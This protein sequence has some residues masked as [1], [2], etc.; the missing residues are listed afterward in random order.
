MYLITGNNVLKLTDISHAVQTLYVA[1]M[2][3]AAD[4]AGLKYWVDNISKGISSLDDTRAAFI[5]QIEYT[6]IYGQ[7]STTALVTKLYQ[8]LFERDPEKNGLDYWVGELNKQ[9]P[10]T[11]DNLVATLVE[12]AEEGAADDAQVLTNKVAVADNFTEQSAGKKVDDNFNAFAK[13][14]VEEV[15]LLASSVSAGNSRVIETVTTLEDKFL[16]AL[17]YERHTEGTYSAQ[18]LLLDVGPKN[19]NANAINLTAPAEITTNSSGQGLTVTL[20]QGE[21]KAGLQFYTIFA[22]QQEVWSSYGINFSSDFDFTN[23]TKLPGLAGNAPDGSNAS[24]NR[25]L[26]ENGGFSFRFMV[27][28]DGEIELYSYLPGKAEGPGLKEGLIIDGA[29]LF[30]ERETD[31]TISQHLTMNTQGQ[32]NGELEVFIN[33]QLALK[34]TDLMLS[35]DGSHGANR[36]YNDIWNGGNSDNFAA[37]NDSSVTIDNI[38]ISTAPITVDQFVF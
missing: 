7:L 38:G 19:I 9:G 23:G 31:Y 13:E 1:I 2:G 28:E 20:P 33:G 4:Y 8:N 12:A 35:S 37:A 34:K 18:Q 25:A 29:D 27:K 15:N 11:P 10:L 26:T 30:L 36:F 32:S 14:V 17:N 22:D 21:I 5:E 3:R 6:A 24:G 16:F